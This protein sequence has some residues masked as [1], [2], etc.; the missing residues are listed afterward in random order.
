MEKYNVILR[1]VK[2]DPPKGIITP[3]TYVHNIFPVC[4]LKNCKLSLNTC[5]K[6]TVCTHL[7]S[8]VCR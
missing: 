7:V 2:V 5:F 1:C 4:S 6:D 3:D 8:T